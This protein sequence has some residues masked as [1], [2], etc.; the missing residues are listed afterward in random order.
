[1]IHDLS[2]HPNHHLTVVE[3][4]K[5]WAVSRQH[6]Y[7]LI[8]SGALEALRFGSRGYRIPTQAAIKFERRTSSLDLANTSDDGPITA[9]TREPVIEKA[10]VKVGP[11]LVR[12]GKL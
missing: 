12:F 6:I 7:K 2:T 1:M 11:Q 3:L 4:A 9:G 10:P 8:E 5:Y